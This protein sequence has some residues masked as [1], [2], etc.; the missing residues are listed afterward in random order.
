M[1]YWKHSNE[2]SLGDIVSVGLKRADHIEYVLIIYNHLYN[3]SCISRTKIYTLDSLCSDVYRKSA[4]YTITPQGYLI[5]DFFVKLMVMARI[6]LSDY[7]QLGKN[8][9]PLKD[10][11]D[12]AGNQ[13]FQITKWNERI[14]YSESCMKKPICKKCILLKTQRKLTSIP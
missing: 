3:R 4:R 1:N 6:N 11:T 7:N 10:V 2:R 8:H 9:K 5:A 14:W 13:I 12:E